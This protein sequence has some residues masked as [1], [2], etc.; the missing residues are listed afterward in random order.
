LPAGRVLVVD[1]S[2]ALRETVA[3]ILSGGGYAVETAE[4]GL[5]ALELLSHSSYDVVILDLA[6]PRLDGFEM[7]RRMEGDQPMVIICSAFEYYAPEQV[8]AEVGPM[9]FRSLRKPVPPDQLLAA[10][11]QAIEAARGPSAG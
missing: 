1:D 2:P 3:D 11:G 8:E 4:D 9:I 10:V 5:A 7:L 6:M